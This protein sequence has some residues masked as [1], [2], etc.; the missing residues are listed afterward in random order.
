MVPEG[1]KRLV[2]DVPENVRKELKIRAAEQ[3][4]T[5]REVVTEILEEYLRKGG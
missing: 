3:E 2:V 1:L 5:V 4:R